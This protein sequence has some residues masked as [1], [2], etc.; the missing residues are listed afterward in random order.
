[1]QDV[2]LENIKIELEDNKQLLMN[3]DISLIDCAIN[4]NDIIKMNDSLKRE[5]DKRCEYFQDLY[6][7]AFLSATSSNP[8]NFQ[9]QFR[10]GHT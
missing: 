1:M 5:I 2:N 6:S 8:D 9:K 7:S 10:N 3:N 4:I